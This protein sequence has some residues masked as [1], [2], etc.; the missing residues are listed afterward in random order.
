MTSRRARVRRFF[1]SAVAGYLV[2]FLCFGAAVE[3]AFVRNCHSNQH[4]WD[5]I[6]RVIAAAINPPSRRGTPLTKAQKDALA[7][8]ASDLTKANGDRP[9]C[10]LL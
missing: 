1:S 9:V 4:S 2:T 5:A 3:I 10:T 6:E 8:Y 7:G